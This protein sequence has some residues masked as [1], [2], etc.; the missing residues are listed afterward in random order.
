MITASKIAIIGI[1]GSGKSTYARDLSKKL[2]LPLYH[3]DSLYWRAGWK[4]VPE[5][6]W[7]QQEAEIIARDQWVIEG[8]ICA[9]SIERLKQADQIIYLD[10]PGLHCCWNGIK[11]WWKHRKNPRP[12]LQ[13]SPEK[14]T[15]EMLKVMLFR[16]ERK[17]I[18]EVLLL[19][20][21]D[22][23]RI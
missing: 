12:E 17:E 9:K 7:L 3:M 22:C 1:S 10:R 11:R 13:G 16:H 19:S 4:E 15:L 23:K 21:K 2:N 8:Y 20:G 6:D 14:L 18:E 5:D